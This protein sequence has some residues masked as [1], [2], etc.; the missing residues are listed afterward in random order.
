MTTTGAPARDATSAPPT[1]R[2]RLATAATATVGAIVGL[3]PHVLHHIGPLLGVALIAGT[4]GTI[5]FGLLGLAASIPMLLRLHR[6]F[7]TWRAPALALALFAT[8]FAVSTLVVG[9]LI[10]GARAPSVP[11]GPTSTFTEPAGHASHHG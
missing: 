7:R 10:S 6:R 1:L 9:P 2:G 3:A 5:L 4:G 8:A 11:T